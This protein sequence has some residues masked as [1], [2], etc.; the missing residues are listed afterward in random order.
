MARPDGMVS[1]HH[2]TSYEN[3]SAE[4]SP[5]LSTTLCVMGGKTILRK[6]LEYLL[7][8][9]GEGLRVVGSYPEEESFVE[10]LRA[11]RQGEFDVLLLIVSGGPFTT[12]HRVN[13]ALNKTE[14]SV[15]LVVLSQQASRGQV[16]A[17]LR[18]GAKAYV[19]LDAE[20][21][22]LFKAIEMASRSKVYLASAAAELLVNDVSTAI[23]SSSN[24]KLP[25]LEL[26]RREIEIVQLLCEG[27]SSKEI[28]R[29]LHISAKTVENHR[30]NIYRKSEVDSIAGLMRHAIQHGLVS[31]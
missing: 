19:N 29:R 21:E 24:S 20:P 1:E 17:S 13:D 14:R 11:G 31:V 22:E 30:Y 18:I 5:A 28:A 16:Y 9:G 7:A 12:F 3:N 26:S 4:L 23:D 25:S 6:S 15:P 27:L 2:E 8:S 10:A